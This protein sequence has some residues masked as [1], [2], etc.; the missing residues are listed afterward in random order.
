[1]FYRHFKLRPAWEERLEDGAADFTVQAADAIHRATAADREIRHVE[2]LGGVA[3]VGAAE[4]EQII[5]GNPEFGFTVLAKAPGHQIRRETVEARRYGRVGGEEIANAR[6]GECDLER[7]AVF[8]HEIARTL[9]NDKARMAFIH[10]A[11]F[12]IETQG[13][14]HA[15]TA[16]TQHALLFEAQLGTAAVEF[17]G[18][19]A[20]L[21]KIRGIV[22]I[23]QI[24]HGAARLNAPGSDPEIGSR[25]SDANSEPST[26]L[27]AHRRDRHLSGIVVGSECDLVA[28][29]VDDLAKISG[30]IEQP[31]S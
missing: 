21:G 16:N 22:G 30:V 25:E 5:K 23:E 14:K 17:A 27:V 11:D 28:G 10:M 9:E 31:D 12:R 18:D 26:L 20:V 7:A 19:A 2:G 13:A 6:G 24:K 29:R 4:R 3:G 8:F 1:M 15:P